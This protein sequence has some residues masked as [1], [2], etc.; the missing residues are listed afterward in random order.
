MKACVIRGARQLSVETYPDPSPGAGEVVIAFGAGGICGSDLHYYKD[1]GV[2]DFKLR[3]PM[4]LGH[5]V[6]GTVAAIGSGVTKVSTGDRVAVNPSRTCGTCAQ[7]RDGRSNL[8]SEVRFFGSAARFP[9]VA[10]GFSEFIV[11]AES[12]CVPFGPSMSFRTAA[13]SEP[14]AVALHAVEKAGRSLV[15]TRVLICGAGP[16][17][18]LVALAARFAGAMEIVVTDLAQ[19]ALDAARANF[20]VDFA[21][22]VR[23]DADKIASFGAGTGTFDVAF[24]ASGSAAALNTC[25]SVVRPGGRIVQVGMFAPGP[26][27]NLTIGR[28]ISRE[29]ELVGTFR[30]HAE[31]EK[32]VRLL[33]RRR[34]LVDPLLTASAPL[35]A[36]PDAFELALDRSRSLKVSLL[37]D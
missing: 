9:H 35:S 8:C 11:A 19:Q 37:P 27:N 28:L 34:I 16:I 13:C 14:L 6:A 32:A 12:Q 23:D 7:C 21:L 30:F 31:F 24:E 15:G 2:G 36:A 17:G 22:N 33:E 20:G 3:E 18:L 4:I 26:V 5:E 29:I 1:G 10:G 25:L